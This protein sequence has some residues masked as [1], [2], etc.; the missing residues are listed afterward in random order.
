[1]LGVEPSRLRYW[2]RLQLVTPRARWGECFYNFGDLVALRTLQS[3]TDRRVPARRVR[4]AVKSFEE[5]FESPLP[6]HQLRFLEQ[7]RDVLVVPPGATRPFSPLKRQWVFPFD[8]QAF[9]KMGPG[10][11]HSMA[12]PT[13]EQLFQAALDCET[14]RDTLPQ[15][16]E[17][18]RRVLD[19]V[20]DWV[21]AHI[22]LGVALYQMGR[23][24]EA[25]AE[26][27]S[28]VQLDPLNGISRYNLGCVLEEQG[29]IE[30]AI[31]HLRRAERAMPAHADVHFNLAL[32]YEKR[33]DRRIAREQWLLY[34]RQAPNG[35]WA[36]EARSH[37]KRCS[38][39]RKSSSPIPFPVKK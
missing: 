24:E 18:Y 33:G 1:M 35:P 28:A 36:E 20:P 8:S 30:E 26:F 4:R 14:S 39:R 38:G 16:V 7:G 34:L 31:N 37:L 6:L 23:A 2:E 5:Q 27:S 29:E 19:L 25:R 10:Q 21:D 12:S 15:A 9:G 17:S 3:L 11:L 32:A 22:N 13:P